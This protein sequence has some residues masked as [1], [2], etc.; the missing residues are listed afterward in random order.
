MGYGTGLEW[1][2]EKIPSHA[3]EKRI[4]AREKRPGLQGIMKRDYPLKP[5]SLV[6]D[7]CPEL[8]QVHRARLLPKAFL[9]V[10]VVLTFLLVTPAQAGTLYQEGSPRLT[11]SLSGTNEFNPG[12]TV[13]I[14]VS[15]RNTGINGIKIVQPGLATRD[16]LPNTAKFLTINLENGGNPVSVKSGPQVIG[17]LPGGS[18]GTAVFSVRIDPSAPSGDYV[19]PV[20][21]RYLYIMS[22]DTFD[23][24]T[25]QYRYG[26]TEGTLPVG[27][28]VRPVVLIEVL[29]ATP[30]NLN[31]GS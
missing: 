28:T 8:P 10:V 5:P 9:I 20:T 21:Y 26:T 2:K 1:R 3:I 30:S 4:R 24:G 12:D 11:A 29:F 13:N 22:A 15:V 25:I 7:Y 18:V 16:D 14:S 23:N 27:L 6:P 31:A 19:L 17:D